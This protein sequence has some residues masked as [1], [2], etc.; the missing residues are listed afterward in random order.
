MKAM[1]VDAQSLRQRLVQRNDETATSHRNGATGFATCE[2]LTRG[3]DDVVRSVHDVAL[4]GTRDELALI[5]LGGYGRRE[6]C[7]HS[8]VDIMV[9]CPSGHRAPPDETAR[10]FLHALWDVGLTVGHSVRTVDDVLKTRGSSIDSWASVLESRFICGNRAL[11]D[12]L[13]SGLKDAARGG[14]DEWFT[15]GVI[16]EI[17]S[18][19]QRFGSSIKLLEPNVKKSAGGLRDVQSAYWLFLSSDQG[20]LDHG[21]TDEPASVRFLEL[22]TGNGLIDASEMAAVRS[23]YEFLLRTRH[24]MHYRRNAPH[25]TLEFALQLEVAEDLGYGPKAELRSVEVFMHDYYMHARAINRLHQRLTSRFHDALADRS[26]GDVERIDDRFGLRG[27]ELVLLNSTDRFDHAETLFETFVRA[28]EQEADLE[29][30]LRAVVEQGA[31]L[32]TPEVCADPALASQFK[33]ILHSK[34]VAATLREMNDLGVLGKYLPE[35]GDLVAFFQHNVY[36][37]FTADE[38]TLMA[39]ANAERLRDQQGVLREVFRNLKRKDVLYMAILLHDIGK[40]RGVGD[41]EITGVEMARAILRR[42]SMEDIADDVT[43]LIRNHLMM[44][45]IAFRRNTHDPTTVKEF[46]A[47]FERPELL[48]YLYLLTYADLSAVN[49]NVW[50]EWKASILQDLYLRTAEVL[51]RN[52]RGDQVDAFHASRRQA[53]H[54]EIVDSLSSML[55]RERVERHLQ[56]IQSDAY[57]AIFTEEEIGRHIE[58]IDAGDAVSTLFT[59]SEGYTDVTI[60]AR[61][62]PFALSKFCAVLSA[63]DANIHDANIFTRDDGKI[64]DRF[65]VGDATSKRQLD[66]RVCKKIADDLTKVMDGR[67][68]LQHLFEAH[69]RRWKRRPK[70]PANPTVRIGVEF[71]DNPRYTILDVYAPDSVGFLYRVTETI[72]RLGLDI[73]FAKIATRVDGIVDAFYVRDRAGSLVADPAARDTIRREIL[74]TIRRLQDQELA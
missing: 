30:R 47:K 25:D 18:R 73:Y 53:V 67:L 34:R 8:D 52:L 22:L 43:F 57:T 49:V 7:P 24:A 28:A 70:L 3:M 46:A 56:G 58:R 37:Y 61:D 32:L 38:H 64:I 36:H 42:V 60:I 72:S 62:A 19:H 35:F 68:D 65:R 9:L 33:K 13:F 63:N 1:S 39:L 11:A 31:D 4:D 2:S 14:V 69:H 50:T 15:E 23:G 44:E 26:R 55:T 17:Q 16:K 71:E 27:G 12:E 21:T 54:L 5:A 29:Y 41:H 10:K 51:R 66:H 40:P 74:E 45:Q 20:F 48:D 59:H 6:L